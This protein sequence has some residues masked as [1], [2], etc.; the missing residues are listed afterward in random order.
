MF[1]QLIGSGRIINDINDRLTENGLSQTEIEKLELSTEDVTNLA[2]ILNAGSPQ[3][4]QRVLE[5]FNDKN[6]KRYELAFTNGVDRDYLGS[7]SNQID[8]TKKMVNEAG[9]NPADFATAAML[10]SQNNFSK[11]SYNNAF[12]HLLARSKKGGSNAY[13]MYQVIAAAK[14]AN[15]ERANHIAYQESVIHQNERFFNHGKHKPQGDEEVDDEHKHH[16]ISEAE[17]CEACHPKHFST[18]TS[19]EAKAQV[20]VDSRDSKNQHLLIAIY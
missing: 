17:D 10:F 5:T 6:V 4:S 7:I 8:K 9:I 3:E 14:K 12:N 16:I 18:R 11:D 15:N 2:D 1:D 20:P 19:E 13:V